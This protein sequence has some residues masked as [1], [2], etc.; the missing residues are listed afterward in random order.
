VTNIHSWQGVNKIAFLLMLIYLLAFKARG[1]LN[2]DSAYSQAYDDLAAML[3]GRLELSFKHAVYFV[4][5]AYFNNGLSYDRFS[6]RIDHLVSIANAWMKTNKLQGYSFADS[7]YVDKNRAIFAVL[8]DT[9][10]IHEGGKTKHL[11]PYTYDFDDN[12]G[13]T[14]WTKM[15]VS[16]LLESRKGNCHSMPYLYKILADE[17]GT[18]CWLAFAP[19]HIYIRNRCQKIGWYNTELTSGQFPVDAWITASGYISIDAIRSGIYMDTLSNRQ[20]IAQCVLDL[21]K[22]YE[23]KAQNNTDSFVINCCDL[24]LKYH[25][26]NIN[27]IIYKAE[28]LKH[29]YQTVQKTNPNEASRLYADMENLYVKAI[30]LGY[31][32]MPEKMYREWMQALMNQKEKYTNKKVPSAVK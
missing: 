17:L 30:D 12:F 32:E 11:M 23:R 19:N 7:I 2:V 14:D 9:L 6:G 5:N 8:K 16:K 29:I 31:K 13:R 15:F 25:P 1:Q 20:A 18:P 21:A 4:E 28:T 22:G 3:D 24:A 26:T 27:A 10:T